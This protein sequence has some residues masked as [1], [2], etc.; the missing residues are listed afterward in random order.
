M[1]ISVLCFL[2]YACSWGLVCKFLPGVVVCTNHS[3]WT[4]EEGA[5]FLE[6]PCWTGD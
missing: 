4:L 2:G 3:Q 6:G 1:F 5:G